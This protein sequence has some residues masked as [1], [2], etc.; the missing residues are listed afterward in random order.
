MPALTTY[1]KKLTF[2]PKLADTL[3]AKYL[4]NTRLVFL[5]VLLVCLIGIF[6]FTSLPRVLNPQIKIPI[7]IVSTLLPGASPKDVESLVTIPVE[8]SLSSL[9]KVKTVTSAS[10]DSVSIVTLEFESGVDPDKAKTDVKSAIDSITT[11]P[12]NA[13]TPNVQKLDFE[14]VPVWTFMLSSKTDYLSLVRFG[15]ILR[16][17]LKDLPS[18]DTVTTTGLDD[19]EIQILLNPAKIA[20]YGINPAT[21]S[22]TIKAATGSFPAGAINTDNATF[23]LTADPTVTTVEDLRKIRLSANG[24]TF[25]LSDIAD[26]QRRTKPTVATSYIASRTQEPIQ[27]IRFDVYKTSSANITQA[28]ADAQKLTD[29]M[30][31]HYGNKFTV[32]TVLNSR[33]QIDRQY[34][35]LLRDLVITISLVFLTLF[36]FLGIRQALVASI[37]IP[38]TFL[39]TFIVMNTTGVALSFIAFFSLLLSLGLLVDDTIV[40]ISA[41]TA[42]Y[43]TDKFSPF[44]AALLVWRDFRTAILTT[45]LTTVWAFVP[46]LLSTGIIGEFIKA[47]PIVVSSAL[48][49]SFGVAVFITM[50]FI[51]FLLGSK[52]PKRVVILLRIIGVI[53]VIWVFFTVAPKG[54]LF[55]PALIL[56]VVTVFIYFQIRSVLFGKIFFKHLNQESGSKNH[57]KKTI[58]HDSLFMIRFSQYLNHGVINFEKIEKKYRSILDR[59]LSNKANRRKTMIAVVTFSLFSYLLLPLGFVKNEFFPKS[60]QEFLYLSLEL[61]AG[62]NLEITKKETL[63]LLQ[64]VR[65][66]SNITF[67]TASLQLGVDPGRGYASAGDNTS[68]ITIVLPPL[69]EH[70]RTSM[71]IAEELRNTYKNYN[72]GTISV[73][74]ESGG[75]PAG[76]D[77]QI[78]LSGEDLTVLDS[79]ANKLQDYMKKQPGETNVAKSIKSGT[80]KIVFVPDYQKMLDASITQDTIGFWLRTYASGFTLE[81]DAKLQVGSNESEDITFR[82]ATTPQT[83][84]G[85]SNIVIPVKDGPPVPLSSLGT[86]E[87]RPNPTLIT[88]EQGK[89][90]I[91]VTAGVTKGV[92]T[93]EENARLTKFADSLHL[94]EGYSWSTGG[95][96]QE[97]NDSVTA[98]LAAMLLSFLLIIITMVLQFSSFRKAF[99]VMLVIPLSIS[100]VFIVFSLTHTPLSFPALI[101]V[102]ALFGIVVKNAILIVDKINKNLQLKM[103]FKE[104]IVDGAESRLEP[105]TL[106]TFATIIG[107]IPITLSDPLWQGLGGAIIAGLFF[108]G[109]IML[110]FIPVVY[111][112]IFHKSS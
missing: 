25:F 7:V 12:D 90:T 109:S 69:K 14:N 77:L 84:T 80:S 6:S 5:V 78:K 88:R 28:V 73:L 44:E 76:A 60:D 27:T 29:K 61:P 36:L 52:L 94:P 107:L 51:V 71:D 47:I 30:T 63:D 75:P 8:D 10:Q 40:M 48:L 43:R 38:M 91:S 34:Y 67:A 100:G 65:Q 106:T 32:S 18:V 105:I 85:M 41:L 81:K 62:T 74:E 58:I 64:K 97:N 68:L 16:D 4:R 45:T 101:G 83:L 70:K 111:Y 2:D 24:T 110:F 53:L 95:V 49:G 56:F 9:Q 1:L 46:L 42:Y 89:R 37:A 79:Y 21:L 57:G 104:A 98:I 66:T 96:N 20:T 35:D 103:E 23:V 33:D 86:F 92:S 17:D 87:L 3:F 93:T 112:L 50:P 59:I 19:E 108:S 15:K 102:L 13:E 55:V 26:I 11:L 72:K 31:A 22:Q 54:V 82:T 39:I 99:I